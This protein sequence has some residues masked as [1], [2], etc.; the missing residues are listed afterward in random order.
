MRTKKK[1][2]ASLDQLI[3]NARHESNNLWH[4]WQEDYKR[5]REHSEI[6]VSLKRQLDEANFYLDDY[7]ELHQKLEERVEFLTQALEDADLL[8]DNLETEY[9]RPMNPPAPPL[10][11]DDAP[12]LLT[13]GGAPA[14]WKGF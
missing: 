14:D 5:Q 8:F 3:E 10:T 11:G 7:E 6:I 12:T 4:Y 13:G 2:L 9:L 1:L